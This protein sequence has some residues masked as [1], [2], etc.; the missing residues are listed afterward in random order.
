MGI[1]EIQKMTNAERLQAM[2]ALWRALCSE[3]E[4]DSPSWHQAVLEG[5]KRK[6]ESGEAKFFSMEEVR[7]RLLE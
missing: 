2:E 1:A 5:R 6:I 7:N 3:E 4:P